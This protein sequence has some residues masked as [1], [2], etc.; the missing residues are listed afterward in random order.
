M[1][2]TAAGFA[3]GMVQGNGGG[4]KCGDADAVSNADVAGIG[5]VGAGG[6]SEVSGGEVW[7]CQ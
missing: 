1:R 5:S 4:D 3:G 6:T 7:D 2:R